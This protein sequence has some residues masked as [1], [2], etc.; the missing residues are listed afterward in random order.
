MAPNAADVMTIDV[1][2]TW[3]SRGWA[4]RSGASLRG[5]YIWRD[6]SQED[7]NGTSQLH[8]RCS[9]PVLPWL[10]TGRKMR[11]G[12]RSLMRQCSCNCSFR[13]PHNRSAADLSPA[14]ST[15]QSCANLVSCGLRKNP[16]HSATF[17]WA[18]AKYGWKAGF[19]GGAFPDGGPL[20]HQTA[21]DWHAPGRLSWSGQEIRRR[22]RR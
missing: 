17:A 4:G 16:L 2:P 10:M 5:T 8:L 3:T 21:P 14:S 20:G 22:T 19:S 1:A 11:T 13:E 18:G 6:C 15:T 12:A 7:H 9:S